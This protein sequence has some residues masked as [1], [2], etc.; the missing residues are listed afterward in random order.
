MLDVVIIGILV[1]LVTSMLRLASWSNKIV[2][3]GK[4]K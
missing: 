3:E 2:K 1:V 4:S